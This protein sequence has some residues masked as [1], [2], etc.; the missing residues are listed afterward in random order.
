MQIVDGRVVSNST[1][2][3]NNTG[4][5][6]TWLIARGDKPEDRLEALTVGTRVEVRH[7]LDGEVAMAIT[8]NALLVKKRQLVTADD[9]EMHP[10]TA[11]GVD[12]DTKEL[13]F[14]VVDGRQDFSR[15]YTMVELGK[16]MLRLGAEDALNFDGGG[17]TTLAAIRDG[18]LRVLNSPSDG[19]QRPVPNGLEVIYRKPDQPQTG[20]SR[21]VDDRHAGDRDDA[22]G[23]RV[24]HL[25][26]RD[27]EVTVDLLHRRR[28]RMSQ[29]TSMTTAP[30]T[31][32][33][34]GR[35]RSDGVLHV[36]GERRGDRN[37]WTKCRTAS[38]LS[39]IVIDFPTSPPA[40]LPPTIATT[41]AAP[42]ADDVVAGSSAVSVPSLSSLQAVR[43]ARTTRRTQE[44]ESSLHGD[45]D[46][47]AGARFRRS[48][49]GRLSGVRRTFSR[50]ELESFRD[51][52]VPDLLP[53]TPDHDLKLLFVG[54]NPGLWTAATQT[55]FAHPG[56]RFYPALLRAGV[57]VE[58]IDPAAGMT[59]A[60]RDVLRA[61]GIG[62]T[63]L[64]PRAPRRR[65]SWATRS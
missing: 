33:S 46:G 54:I 9:T 25:P 36:G 11:I 15:G 48:D 55:H 27:D 19:A 26:G 64:V 44:S 16:M 20:A 63:N 47:T 51:A 58:P 17:S 35:V 18:K 1:T 57:I 52:V 5:K 30:R 3:P 38:S 13:I 10:R 39:R 53:T 7:R 34:A 56:N 61:R 62:I 6:G 32:P 4:I 42:G 12:R 29:Q 60:E 31:R 49:S 41:S 43:T 2:I 14:L 8:G 28:R 22:L 40:A 23:M 59:E 37:C 21:Q 65:R 45:W 50:A 24:R